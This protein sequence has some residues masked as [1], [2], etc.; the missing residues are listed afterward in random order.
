MN[1]ALQSHPLVRWLLDSESDVKRAV[2][3][4]AAD[5]ANSDVVEVA[6]PPTSADLAQ[7]RKNESRRV[8][9]PCVRLKM[10]LVRHHL[11]GAPGIRVECSDADV[12]ELARW[13][14]LAYRNKGAA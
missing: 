10:R 14:W 4:F 2:A 8:G 1:L 9:L 11:T 7:Y 12:Q 6:G 5:Q 13:R 3:A